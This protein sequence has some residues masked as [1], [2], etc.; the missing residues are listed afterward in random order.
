M[1]RKRRGFTLIE[2]LVVIAIIAILA[3][4]L[5]PAISKAR[6]KA[7][8]I[9]CVSH[10]KQ[11][12]TALVMYNGDWEGW[13]PSVDG[14]ATA[15]DNSAGLN[16]LIENDYLTIGRMYTCPST[17][18][19][20]TDDTL[21]PDNSQL[22]YYY[23]GNI[24]ESEVG[25]ETAVASDYCAGHQA[26]RWN[27]NKYGNVLFGDSHVQGYQGANWWTNLNSDSTEPFLPNRE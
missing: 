11:M 21:N 6:E 22:D 3:G 14:G 5:M 20:A 23:W 24:S 26:G 12:G 18:T 27:H 15:G 7:R 8:Q 25:T 17:K 19:T 2:L 4:M 10:L 13:Y 16:L 9:D 1:G